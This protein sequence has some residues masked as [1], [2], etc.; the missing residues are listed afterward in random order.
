MTKNVHIVIPAYKNP[1]QLRKCLSALDACV[2]WEVANGKEIF[3]T[4]HIED[5]TEI[6][7][8]FAKAVNNGL[9]KSIQDNA[10]YALVLNQDCYLDSNAIAEMVDFMD[11]HP[12]CFHA[13]IKQVLES[14][15]DQIIH[16]G[17]LEAYPNGR[18]I[19]GSV[20]AG[21]C[22]SNAQMKW[23]NAAC[24]IVNVKLIPEV[25]LLDEKFF[26][27]GCDSDW[28]YRARTMGFEVWYIGSAVCT[29]EQGIT[30]GGNAEVNKKMYLDMVYWRNKW[31]G[32]D[33]YREL[34]LE[35]FA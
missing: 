31:L 7:L 29:H 20:K 3:H 32:T 26:L 16:G 18:H 33:L 17:T 2:D 6:N 27:I 5:N 13:S 12:N 1:D 30:R 10:D 4:R 22:V 34:S 23:A 21:D 8:G 19:G 25:G 15:P 28:S 35:I 14:D 9:R 24:L 11:A